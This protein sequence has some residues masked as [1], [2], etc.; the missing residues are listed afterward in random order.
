MTSKI[1]HKQV[2]VNAA[3]DEVWSAWSTVAGA[4]SFFAPAARIEPIPGGRYELLFDMDEVPGRQGSEGCRV[5]EIEPNERLAFEWNA[6]PEFPE[7]RGQRTRVEVRLSKM[8]AKTTGVDLAMSGWGEGAEWEQVYAYFDRAWEV[9]L[10][11]LT[12]RFEHGPLDWEDPYRP[13]ARE[14]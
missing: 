5:L 9:V 11:R 3:L 6:P 12:Y 2:V 13:E 14:A 1:M 8:A 4:R 10:A 7:I